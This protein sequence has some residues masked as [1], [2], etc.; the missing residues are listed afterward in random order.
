MLL[1]LLI[2]RVVSGVNVMSHIS[3]AL[4]RLSFILVGKN[5]RGTR[6]F[7]QRIDRC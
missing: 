4:L 5:Y 1:R 2:V 3:I 7:G 6:L